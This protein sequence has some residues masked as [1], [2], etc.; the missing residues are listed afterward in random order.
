MKKIHV[1][2]RFKKFTYK[3]VLSIFY[4]KRHLLGLLYN[5]YESFLVFIIGSVGLSQSYVFKC[6]HSWSFGRL[7]DTIFRGLASSGL[8]FKQL[9][10]W[11]VGN[12]YALMLVV[13]NENGAH[14]WPFKARS[15]MT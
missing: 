13:F 8:F 4:R 12:F 7:D 11:G 9:I 6:V 14:M 2:S 3:D 5:T 10:Q 1:R 15:A